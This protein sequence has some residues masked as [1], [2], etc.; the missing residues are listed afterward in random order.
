MAAWFGH[1]EAGRKAAA[2][3]GMDGGEFGIPDR[4]VLLAQVAEDEGLEFFGEFAGDV[5][6]GGIIR[7]VAAAGEDALF[8]VP[9]VRADFE[10]V[11][12]VVGLEQEEVGAADVEFD[13]VG[14]V[15]EVG[16]E[17]DF[18]VV[19]GDGIGDGIDGVVGEG[20][21]LHGEVAE[22]DAGAGLECLDGGGRTAPVDGRGGEVG[23]E[24]GD[25][26]AESA[27]DDGEAGDMV[28]VLMGDE[29]GVE[30]GGVLADEGEAAEGLFAVE[31]GIDEDAGLLRGDESGIA[32]AR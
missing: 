22:V 29:D 23:E 4:V 25:A 21:G 27:V 1:E 31:A 9:G 11:G 30:A 6:A 26:A 24:D 12:V 28:G 2:L 7:E 15:A 14:D 19:G 13:A 18:D 17:G 3:Q 20:E 5:G 10:E 16:D 8:D 32:G